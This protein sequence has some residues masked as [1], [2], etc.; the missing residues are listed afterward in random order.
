MD[1]FVNNVGISYCGIIMDIIVDVDKRVMEINYFG[2]VVLMKVFLFFMIK[3][4]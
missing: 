4:R 3:R 1:I 2:L